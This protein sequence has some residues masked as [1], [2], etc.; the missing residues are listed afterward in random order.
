MQNL[1]QVIPSTGPETI[2][3]NQRPKGQETPESQTKT[4]NGQPTLPSSGSKVMSNQGA[5]Q[6]LPIVSPAPGKPP[7]GN[8]SSNESNSNKTQSSNNGTLPHTSTPAPQNKS[9]ATPKPINATAVISNKPTSDSSKIGGKANSSSLSVKPNIEAPEKPTQ[10]PQIVLCQIVCGSDCC[11]L[12]VKLPTTKPTITTPKNSPTTRPPTSARSELKKIPTTPPEVIAG[13]PIPIGHPLG[14]QWFP[15]VAHPMSVGPAG[16]T[17][18]PLS[19]PLLP[20]YITLAPATASP[21][22]G[23]ER[24]PHEPSLPMYKKLL[25]VTALPVVSTQKERKDPVFIGKKR[26]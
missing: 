16:Q 25:P 18:G 10:K 26:F 6:P 13:P 24:F 9:P 11:P 1:N 3:S 20:M 23:Q 15:Q 12:E 8:K 14:P 2:K 7:E 22:I 5:K 21:V 4:P 19:R 17:S